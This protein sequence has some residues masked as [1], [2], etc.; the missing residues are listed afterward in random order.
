MTMNTEVLNL[1]D[2]IGVLREGKKGEINVIVL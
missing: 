1:K 2:K